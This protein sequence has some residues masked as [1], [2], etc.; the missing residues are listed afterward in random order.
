MR[1]ILLVA[2]YEIGVIA[3]GK[4][5]WVFTLALPLIIFAANFFMQN[6]LAQTVNSDVIA[7]MLEPD[8]RIISYVDTANLIATIPADYEADRLH[9]LLSEDAA[10][11]EME[12]EA[13]DQFFVI[14]PNY[15]QNGR[16]TIFSEQSLPIMGMIDA[17][18]LEELL[19]YN[20][21]DDV[22]TAVLFADP[23]PNESLTVHK[24][25]AETERPDNFPFLMVVFGFFFMF[26]FSGGQYMLRSIS[27]ETKNR[28]LEL[29]LVSINSR[30][31]MWGK[32][33]GLS[34][35]ALIQILLWGVLFSFLS[36]PASQQITTLPQ[37]ILSETELAEELTFTAVTE[38]PSI[39]QFPPEFMVWAAIFLFL[40]FFMM[41]SLFLVI[42]VVSPKTQFAVQISGIIL[43]IMLFV[44]VLNTAVFVNPDSTS[45]LVLSLFP[46][47]APISMT[48]RIAVSSPPLW[49]I[50]L[51]LLGLVVTIYWLVWLASR[52]V[53]AD[54]LLV[55]FSRPRIFR[56]GAN[57]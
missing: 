18:Q 51:S 29:L 39:A 52:L 27:R 23:I 5:F 8:I 54:T 57:G 20:L 35:I 43:F 55:G 17:N 10:M 25:E 32:M 47:S 3:D 53:G 13:I 30:H 6:R 34:S 4:A 11:A 49:Q 22:N 36:S 41:T 46:L 50:G 28:T 12:A 21:L 45:A 31:L 2:R 40:G 26:L 7:P 14:D 44:F 33:I 15:L 16:V 42:G 48:T 37:S 9:R 56:W 24:I 19:A 38:P 1:T